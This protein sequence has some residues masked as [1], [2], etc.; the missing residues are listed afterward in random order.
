MNI[1]LTVQYHGKGRYR[2]GLDVA[3]SKKI[4]KRKYPVNLAFND[5]TLHLFTACGVPDWKKNEE[6]DRR[7]KGYD[8]NHWVLSDWLITNFYFEKTKLLFKGK[9][10]NS[11][12]CLNLK[13]IEKVEVK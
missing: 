5:V 8:L 4:G 9:F 1:I 2:L 10:S 7:K 12:S 13:F 11:G 6:K 3:L